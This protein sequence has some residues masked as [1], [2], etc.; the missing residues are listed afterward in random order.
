MGTL[1]NSDSLFDLVKDYLKHSGFTKTLR[2]LDQ[3]PKKPN[4]THLKK[5]IVDPQLKIRAQVSVVDIASAEMF[6]DLQNG[7][8]MHSPSEFDKSYTVH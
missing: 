6:G 8:Q 5:R 1:Q 3:N 4:E 7:Q 2:L